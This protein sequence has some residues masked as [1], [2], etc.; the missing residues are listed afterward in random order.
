MLIAIVKEDL[1]NVIKQ[2]IQCWESISGGPNYDAFPFNPRKV[3]PK[4]LTRLG[5]YKNKD[6]WIAGVRIKQLKEYL[7]E[8]ESTDQIRI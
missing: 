7:A 3:D 5:Y 6:A 4:E 1:I 2:E 8:I